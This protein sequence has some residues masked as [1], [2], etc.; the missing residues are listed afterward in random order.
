M[1]TFDIYTVNMIKDYILH[2][3]QENNR[4]PTIDNILKCDHSKERGAQSKANSTRRD[5]LS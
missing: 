5:H 1:I 4:F 3:F 2:R